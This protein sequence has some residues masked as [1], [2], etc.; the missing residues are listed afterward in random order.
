[1][2]LLYKYDWLKYKI[3]IISTLNTIGKYYM[4]VSVAVE[5]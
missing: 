2:T 5:K 3:N 1:M 4:Y